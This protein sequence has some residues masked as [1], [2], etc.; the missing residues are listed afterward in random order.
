MV[1]PLTRARRWIPECWILVVALP[2]WWPA[3][4]TE[5]G[6]T[7]DYSLLGVWRH[8][9]YAWWS[10]EVMQMGRPLTAFL[11]LAIAEWGGRVE[12]L[13]LVRA[14][15]ALA[16]FLFAVML[17]KGLA[18]QGWSSGTATGLTLMI[19]MTPP[20][21]VYLCWASTLPAAWGA[22]GALAAGLWWVSGGARR[23]PAMVGTGGL[24]VLVAACYQP[25]IGFFWLLPLAALG[26]LEKDLRWRLLEFARAAGVFL[27]AVV[28]Y[29]LTFRLAV[30]FWFPPTAAVARSELLEDPLGKL[31]FLREGVLPQILGLW[32]TL[33]PAGPRPVLV[34][35]ALLAT[36][37]ASL[38]YLRH[39]GRFR[40]W[41]LVVGGFALAAFFALLPELALKN[42]QG[43]FRLLGPA[44]G[45]WLLFLLGGLRAATVGRKEETRASLATWGFVGLLVWGAWQGVRDGFVHPQ[46]REWVALREMVSA[47]AGEVPPGG[48]VYR[49]PVGWSGAQRHRSFH[50][51][52]MTSS[53]TPWGAEYMLFL[54]VEERFGWEAA[55]EAEILPLRPEEP[56]PPGVPLLDGFAR[57]TGKA[58][59]AAQ[60]EV[61][62]GSPLTFPP[63]GEVLSVGNRWIFHPSLGYA[64]FPLHPP[65]DYETSPPRIELP[66]EGHWELF[67]LATGGRYRIDPA[68]FPEVEETGTGRRLRLSLEPSGGPRPR[69]VESP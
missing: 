16:L 33:A 2:V 48:L 8:P 50:E 25:S 51:F 52:G 10:G 34:Q 61:P 67:L 57:F 64:R 47:A 69:E 53:A 46:H 54:L 19:L 30:H 43:A 38:G 7:D 18:R 14:A 49:L 9:L 59:P 36:L 63:L 28:V 68:A 35:G 39:P 23:W 12:S 22:L 40:H 24:L 6:V 20:F 44:Y 32:S 31:Q 11:Y 26:Q 41:A 60:R 15:S 37:A 3:F 29:Y 66:A 45:V 65:L 13:G 27:A 58:A 21:V 56:V 17:R 62:Y 4:T 42:N 1:P 5:F 55:L